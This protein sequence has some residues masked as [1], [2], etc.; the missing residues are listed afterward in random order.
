[1]SPV[2]IVGAAPH[3]MA[4]KVS[5]ATRQANG[6]LAHDSRHMRRVSKRARRDAGVAGEAGERRRTVSTQMRNERWAKTFVRWFHID[7]D[8]N[9]DDGG[10]GSGDGRGVNVGAIS[11]TATTNDGDGDDEG[12]MVRV[13]RE[14][15]DRRDARYDADSVRN[16]IACLAVHAYKQD[17]YKQD[18]DS[19]RQSLDDSAGEMARLMAAL[20]DAKREADAY[21]CRA[22]AS[23][24]RLFTVCKKIN[25]IIVAMRLGEAKT[26]GLVESLN[27]NMAVWEKNF[28]VLNDDAQRAR[29]REEVSNFAIRQL[30]DHMRAFEDY[31]E[32]R[33]N[34][35]EATLSARLKNQE[36]ILMEKVLMENA[37]VNERV[38]KLHQAFR[39]E[40]SDKIAGVIVNIA[41]LAEKKVNKAI[42][43]MLA[44]VSSVGET[45]C[46]KIEHNLNEKVVRLVERKFQS[47]RA[48]LERVYFNNARV[49]RKLGEMSNAIEILFQNVP[50]L[51][52][53]ERKK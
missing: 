26:R 9:G 34:A 15:V 33:C 52:S 45:Q 40:M 4:R 44:T 35:M 5:R 10:D 18:I 12:G 3:T 43:K 46:T 7:D 31:V 37:A 19:V 21:G 28:E 49:G 16:I 32:K 11:Y 29:E 14:R 24:A 8:D 25:E 42:E 13:K 47:E 27:A 2:S 50:C 22:N 51:P 38:N 17:R 23:D 53:S 20:D 36:E 30:Q 6:R 39:Q 1:M 48:N 41:N